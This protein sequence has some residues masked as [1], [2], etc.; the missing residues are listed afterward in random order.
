MVTRGGAGCAMVVAVAPSTRIGVACGTPAERADTTCGTTE[1]LRPGQCPDCRLDRRLRELLTG[2]DGTIHPALDPLHQALAATKPPGTALR[3][4]AKDLVSTLLA[5]LATGRRQLTHAELDSLP[6]SLALA[7]LRS[8]LVAT[9]TL[10]PR[11]E[12]M[13]RLERLLDD[14]LATRDDPDQR[15]LLHRY[16]A[17][18]LLRRL[19]RRNSGR[20]AT[21][22]QLA[23][24]RQRVRAAVVFLD[25]L[26]AQH[27]TLAACRQ[28]DL[29]RWLSG[30]GATRRQQA[31]HFVRWA[32]K[33][34]LTDLVFP[35]TRWQG[36]TRPIHDQARWGPLAVSSTTTPSTRG[37]VSPASSSFSTPRKPPRPAG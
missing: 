30:T 24:V 28:A 37:T 31:G 23:V 9:A 25:W 5:D 17:W 36:P 19:R 13:A 18:Q 35:A 4:L 6:P 22:Q 10:A 2:P 12:Q 15:Q 21:H 3:W 11:D 20:D 32:A 1:P 27:R 34:H 14:L 7:H 16:A 8:V 26:A 33:Q 29:E